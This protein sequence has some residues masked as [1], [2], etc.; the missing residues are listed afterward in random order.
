MVQARAQYFRDELIMNNESIRNKLSTPVFWEAADTEENEAKHYNE[1]PEPPETEERNEEIGIKARWATAAFA[2]AAAKRRA[3]APSEAPSEPPSEPP[4]E[5]PS[6]P[7]SEPP[8]EAPSEPPAEPPSKPPA[9]PDIVRALIPVPIDLAGEDQEKTHKRRA[10]KIVLTIIAIILAVEIIVLGIH[11]FAP[12]SAAAKAIGSAQTGIFKTVT[13]FTDSI[14]G[15]FTEKDSNDET[16]VPED[17]EKGTTDGTQ[18]DQSAG[19]KQT[20]NGTT[21]PAPDPNPMADKNALVTSQ[22]GNNN[23]IEQVK[24]N[25]AL[26][27]KQGKKAAAKACWIC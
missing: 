18:D 2:A 21:A 13:G 20:D 6:E 9:E 17:S 26:A 27:Y 23:N 22:L 24:A 5:A 8:S 14:R 3:E 12:D 7:P 11:Y 19:Q 4:A 1:A 15:L 25:D 10:G 16:N